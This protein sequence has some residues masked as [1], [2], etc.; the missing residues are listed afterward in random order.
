MVQSFITSQEIHCKCS[1]S[2]VK[3][4]GQALSNVSTANNTLM[5][6]IG[7]ANSNLAWRR[8][9]S[10]KGLAWLGRPQ[11]A[12][13][14]QM[15]RFLYSLVVFATLSLFKREYLRNETNCW[16]KRKTF[17][18]MKTIYILPKCGNLWPTN[19]WNFVVRVDSLSFVFSSFTR[20]SPNRTQSLLYHVFDSERYLTV[21]V[22]NLELPSHKTRG[23]RSCLFL[24][25]VRRQPPVSSENEL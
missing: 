3:G 24:V 16:Q 9:E 6:W 14:S 8:N 1:R 13:H 18:T 19:G 17:K 15:P 12:M 11:V 25:T 21:N 5:D 20:R 10:R 2:E 4:Q 23:P 7:S 22:K